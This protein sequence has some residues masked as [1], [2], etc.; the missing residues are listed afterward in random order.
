M[1]LTFKN[2]DAVADDRF[3]RQWFDLEIS[4]LERTEPVSRRAPRQ[5]RVRRGR[6]ALWTPIKAGMMD[7]P[8]GHV[9][10]RQALQMKEEEV[11]KKGADV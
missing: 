8:V 3:P 5:H 6:Q 11:L 1:V 2:D 9:F 10:R 7:S 4:R